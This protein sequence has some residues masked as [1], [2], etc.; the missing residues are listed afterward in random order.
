MGIRFISGKKET[1]HLTG[2]P[3][4]YYLAYFIDDNKWLRIENESEETAFPVLAVA[5]K[6]TLFA[7]CDF[8]RKIRVYDADKGKV[9][10]EY[11]TNIN[12]ESIKDMK[13]I[14]DDQYLIF[15]ITNGDHSYEYD[16]GVKTQ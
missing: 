12:A 11:D 16:M 10:Y 7:V 3:V 8:D 2:T 9:L 13:F 1:S 5:D 4:D 15:W 6:K 14:L